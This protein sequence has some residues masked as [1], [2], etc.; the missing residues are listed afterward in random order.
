[1]ILDDRDSGYVTPCLVALDR[2]DDYR[3]RLELAGFEPR[4]FYLQSNDSTHDIPWHD[5]AKS[6]NGLH[7]PFF[8]DARDLFL[9]FRNDES[10]W[11]KRI[12]VRLQ[13]TP[14]P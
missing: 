14:S 2:G 9:P 13:P 7:T 1:M 6:P 11:P 10:H 4:E 12:F 8:L 5:G 3:V